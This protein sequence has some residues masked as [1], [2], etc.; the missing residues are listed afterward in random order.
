MEARIKFSPVSVSWSNPSSGDTLDFAKDG[1]PT[2][3]AMKDVKPGDKIRFT[4]LGQTNGEFRGI[5]R[6]LGKFKPLQASQPLS[7]LTV[8][9]AYLGVRYPYQVAVG[10]QGSGGV[11]PYTWSIEPWTPELG[12]RPLT[13]P[14]IVGDSLIG[15]LTSATINQVRIKMTDAFGFYVEKIINLNSTSA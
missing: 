7:I 14:Q 10:L 3:I 5:I 9:S 13:N 8:D 2:L 4:T 1:N 11:V 6:Y 12:K 15:E